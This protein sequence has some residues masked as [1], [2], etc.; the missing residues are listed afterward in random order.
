MNRESQGLFELGLNAFKRGNFLEA[1]KFFERS[2]KTDPDN[3]VC[4]SYIGVCIAYE[5][6][7]VVQGIK[8]CEQAL[9]KEPQ[10]TDSYC[11]LGKVYLRS[12]NNFKAIEVFREGLRI[13]RE[14]REIIQEL[15]ALGLRKKLIV[16]FLSRNNVVNK[17]LGMFLSRT[18]LR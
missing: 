13:D 7:A 2:I 8:M 9:K 11:N 4:Q 16:S 15:Q 6:G 10:I 1:L 14:N 12:G 3:P 5:R 17:Y 18:G